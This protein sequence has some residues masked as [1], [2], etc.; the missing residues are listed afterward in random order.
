MVIQTLSTK[1]TSAIHIAIEPETKA[2]LMAAGKSVGLNLS[3]F[4]IT[5]AIVEARRLKLNDSVEVL[6]QA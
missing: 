3:S 4:L 1:K 5:N 6:K 2:M